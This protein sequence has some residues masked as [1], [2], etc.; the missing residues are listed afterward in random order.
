[1]SHAAEWLLLDGMLREASPFVNKLVD[2][3]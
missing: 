1:M 3:I 2:K